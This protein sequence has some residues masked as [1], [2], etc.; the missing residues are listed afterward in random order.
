MLTTSI[1]PTT[2]TTYGTASVGQNIPFG[3]TSVPMPYGTASA[4]ITTTY[5]T[6]S[7]G[8]PQYTTIG[9]SAVIGNQGLPML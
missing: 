7:V 6:T 3:T 5:G 1:V 8:A 2:T 4:P 9:N